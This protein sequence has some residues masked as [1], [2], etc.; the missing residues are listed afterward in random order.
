[1]IIEIGW[2]LFWAICISSFW[3]AVGISDIGKNGRR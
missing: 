1:M 2:R 3:L